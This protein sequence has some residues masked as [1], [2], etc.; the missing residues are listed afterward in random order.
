M[1]T[2][3]HSMFGGR[4]RVGLP[5]AICMLAAHGSDAA[6]QSHRVIVNGQRLSDAQVATLSRANCRDIPNGAYWL[7]TRTGAWGYAGDPR[8][9]GVFGEACHGGP[10][11]AGINRDGTR[12]PFVTLRRAE[13][14]ADR[15][16]AQGYHVVAFHNGNGYFIR[17]SR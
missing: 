5:V 9:Q 17:V 15:Y 10:E 7:N 13:E 14:E 6:A 16:R 3:F 2:M 1:M 4:Q 11:S 8:V 12:G